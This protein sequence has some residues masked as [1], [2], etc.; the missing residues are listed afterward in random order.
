MLA[1]YLGGGGGEDEDG[2]GD[3]G[4]PPPQYNSPIEALCDRQLQALRHVVDL[5]HQPRCGVKKD[6]EVLGG[7]GRKHNGG[8]AAMG[9]GGGSKTPLGAAKPHWGQPN[10]IECSQTPLGAAKPH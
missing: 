1:L 6:A 7:E 5:S 8:G 3:E 10:P 9:G 4:P 2:G